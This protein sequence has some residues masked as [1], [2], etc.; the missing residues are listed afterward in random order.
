MNDYYVLAVVV[1][2]NSLMVS[3]SFVLFNRI[4][5]DGYFTLLLIMFP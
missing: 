4:V 2:V 5:T 1:N 3:K